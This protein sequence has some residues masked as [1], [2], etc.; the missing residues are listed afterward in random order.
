MVAI[1]SG[2]SLGLNLG[3]LATLGQQG[4][5]GQAAQGS[6]GER[7]YVDGTTGNLVLQREDDHLLA[8]G[9][10]S[11]A[12]RTYNSQGLFNDDNGDNWTSGFWVKPL[13]LAGTLN[14]AG[15][16]L[17]R[18]DS[19][20]SVATYAFS[21]GAYRST[22]G[23][24]AHDTITYVAADNQLEWREGS[25]GATQ[26]YE[27]G[28]NFRLLSAR[29][30]SGNALVY[31]YD[32]AGRVVS[33]ATAS[34]DVTFYDYRDGNLQQIRTVTAGSQG[35][36]DVRYA[37]DTDNRLVTVTVDLT[38]ADGSIA[39]GKAYTTTYGYEAGS[40]RIA[41][42][43]QSDGTSLSF[44]YTADGKVA[45][46]TNALGQATTFTY[47]VRSV[48]VRDAAN[49]AYTYNFDTSGRLAQVV[50]P[51]GTQYFTFGSNGD[52]L[53]QKDAEL[54]STT[55]QYDANGNQVL[56]CD[57]LG[58][59]I[60]R[61]FDARNQ[62][63]TETAYVV[64]DPDGA[65]VAT[66]QP[67]R[68]LTTRYVYD[69]AGRSLL[70]F[71]L[72]AEGRVTENRYDGFGQ[73]VAT[74]VYAGNTYPVGG[75]AAT[76][77]PPEA[78]LAAWAASQ[79]TGAVQRQDFSYDARGALVARTTFARVD[80]AGAGV[81]DGSESRETFAYDLNGRLLQSVSATG[82]STAFSY[83][84]LGRILGRT[85][86]LGQLTATQYLDLAA[87]DV[88]TLASGLAS[89][90]TY[91]AA[92]RLASLV[93]AAPD[94]TVLGVTHYFY[95]AGGRLVATQDPTG[96]CQWVLYDS[97]GRKA[98]D[99]DGN[100]SM[101]EYKYDRSDRLVGTI[102]YGNRVAAALLFDA[103]GAPATTLTLSVRPAASSADVKTWRTYDAA[104]RP[105][106]EAHTV[107]TANAVAVVETRYDGASR[108]MA[109]VQYA[110]TVSTPTASGASFVIALPAAS[111]SDRVTRYFYDGDGLRVGT[112]DAEGYLTARAYGAGGQLAE[113]LAYATATSTDPAQQ[114]GGDLAALRPAASAS[115]IRT[116]WL[117][118]GKGLVAGQVDGEGYLTETVR[119]AD[120]NAIRTVRYASRVTQTAIAS[121]TV[122]ALRPAGQAAD[123]V[124]RR[125]YDALGRL[126]QETNPEGTVTQYAYDVA[127]RLVATT[128][129]AGTAEARQQLERYDLQGRLTG[130]LGAEGAALL[131]PGQTQAEVD[132]IWAQYGSS[133]A[134]DAAG[135]R[136][137]T[138]DAA[139]NRTLFFYNEDGALTHT[140]N[141]LGEVRENLYDA[142]GRLAGTVAYA[143]RID[144]S[145]LQGGLVTAALTGAITSNTAL[146]SRTTISYTREDLVAATTDALGNVSSHAY[147]VFGDE[148]RLTQALGGAATLTTTYST[149]RRGLRTGSLAD[150][151][152][153][154]ASATIQYDAFGRAVRTIDA[155]GNVR[156][157]AYDRLGR[158]VALRDPLGGASTSSFD[159]FG[160]VLTQTD[161][162]GNSTT[163]AY[164][165][166]ARTMSVTTPEGFRTVT[167]YTRHG[168]VLS[169]T[170][171]KGQVTTYAYDREGRLLRTTTPLTVA[172]SSYDAAGRLLAS[173]DAAGNGVAYTYDAAN[174]L[175]ART[176]DPA[177]LA[178][179]TRYQYDAKGQQVAVTDADGVLTN[180]EYDRKGQVLKQTVDPAGLKLQTLYSYDAQGRVLSVTTP[181]GS[182]TQ[183][184][185]DALGRRTQERVDPNGLNL[186][187]Q[188][189]YDGNGN[190][191]TA[192]DATGNVT[193]YVYDAADRLQFTIDAAGGV[194]QDSYD[195]AGR[196]VRSASYATPINA[197]A[198]PAAPGAAQVQALLDAS[199]GQAQVENRVYD[200]D[201]RL[202]ATVDGTGAVLRYT[203]DA[204]GN[205]VSRTAYATA[206]D[207][208]NWLPG[209]LPAP[210][211]DAAR[212]LQLRTVYDALNRAVY[213]IDAL[214]G[215]VFQAYD[216]NGRV[217]QRIAYATPVKAGTALTQ[218]ALAAATRSIASAA[219]DASTRNVYDAAGRL[220]WSADGLG[221][222]TQSVYD[223]N[224]NLL[225]LVEYATPVAAGAAP[226]SVAAADG[227]RTTVMAYDAANR[228]V[229]TIDA[230]GA[231]TEQ[232]Y[233]GNGQ[234][235][236]RTAYATPLS[237]IPAPGATLLA[238]GALL[239]AAP[240]A[241]R[242]TSF[243]Y[244]AAGRQTLAI[245]AEGG[246]VETVWDAAGRAMRVTQYATAVS[247]GLL[248]LPKAAAGD[249]VTRNTYDAA[250]RL[251][252]SVDALGVVSTNTYD[253]LGRLRSVL[254]DGL[255]EQFAYD[256]AG[257]VVQHTDALGAVESFR[258]NALGN[259]EGFTD[260]NGAYWQYGYDA[261]GRLASE[262]SPVAQ[263]RNVA[264]DDAGVLVDNGV[265]SAS[266][267]TRYAYDALGRLVSRTEAAG[268]PQEER[269]TRYDYDPLGHQVKVTQPGFQMY[270]T[271]ED[272]IA[273][274][275]TGSAVR[276]EKAVTPQTIT[277]YD[278]LG[279][280]V[281]NRELAT[282]QL[283]QKVYDRLGR[284]AYDID[285]L[286]YVTAY[287]RNAFGEV[288]QLVRYE[289][290]TT[291]ANRSVTQAAQAAT[292][293]ETLA[294]LNALPSHDLDRTLLA[295]YDR[296]G[297]S[298]EVGQP[299]VYVS[300]LDASA[301][302]VSGSVPLATRK[303]YDAFG[304]VIAEQSLR[305]AA[306]AWSTTRH[307]YDQLGREVATIDPLG[308][309]T[310]RSF[311]SRGNL[312]S[313]REYTTVVASW[314]PTGPKPAAGADDRITEYTYD[315]L[316]RKLTETR[317]GIEY[318][319]APD[320]SSTRGAA[321]TRYAYDAVGNQVRVT[322]ALGG[323][324]STWYDALGRV[325]AVAAPARAVDDGS[326]AATSRTPLT[327][328]ARDARGNAVVT[329]EYALGAV[330]G[331]P[332]PLA[333]SG[334]DRNSFS[335]FDA[336][337][338]L[339]QTVDAVGAVISFS[340]D[341]AG[342]VAKR[343]QDVTDVD[344][345]MRTRFEVSVYDKLGRLLE[346]RTPASTAVMQGS[347][348]ADVSQAQA[349]LVR[350]QMQYNGF[351][352]LVRRGVNGSG[353]EF[354]EYDKAGRL[355]RTNSGDG[356]ARILLYD[357][358]G[359]VT[360]E[361]RSAGAGLGNIDITQLPNA[362]TADANPMTRRTDTR[363]DAAGHVVETWQAA[364]EEK[365]VGVVGVQKQFITATI[366]GS[367]Q[368]TVVDWPDNVANHVVLGWNS[369]S[370]LGSGD[371]KVHVEYRTP[372]HLEG[373]G[374]DPDG[375][376]IPLTIVGGTRRSYDSGI[377]TAEEGA[378]RADLAW[379]EPAGNDTGVG[380]IDRIV[381]YKKDVDG[382]WQAV[383]DEAPG[384]GSDQLDFAVPVESDGAV[385]L[386]MRP[387]GSSGDSG[388]WTARIVNF[389]DR[390]FY[391]TS[392]LG[393]GNYEYRVRVTPT[394]Q[395]SR[396]SASGTVQLTRPL[397]NAITTPIKFP[398]PASSLLAWQDPAASGT[399]VP[400]AFRYRQAGST[401]D[402]S[403][404][405]ISTQGT[406]DMVDTARLAPGT[407]QFELLWM[408]L[409]KT[410]QHATGTFTITP[411]QAGYT[412]PQVNLR[413]ITN[414]QV[415]W[416]GSANYSDPILTWRAA[417]ATR[418]EYQRA[419]GTW[420]ALA[421]D[422]S[423]QDT[424]IGIPLGYQ[425]ASLAGIPAGSYAYRIYAGSPPTQQA[426]GVLT[427]NATAAG[428]YETQYVSV[429]VYTPRV[430]FYL[431][432]TQ[433]VQVTGPVTRRVWVVDFV[434]PFASQETDVPAFQIGHYEDR[435]TVETYTVDKVVGQQ[436]FYAYDNDGSLIYDL[437][438]TTQAQQVW[439]G[440]PMPT[441][442]LQDTTP[443]W[444]PA[445]VVP[446][447]PA[448][449]SL[450]Q[451]L[452]A[453][454]AAISTS[455][456]DKL[457][458][459]A[460][461]SQNTDDRWLRPDVQ[462]KTDRWGNVV[463]TTDPRSASWK[464]SYRYNASNQLVQQVQPDD[465]GAIS[466][467]SP[468]TSIFYDKLGR[469]VAVRDANGHVS[470]Q[471]FDAAGNLVL[472]RHADAYAATYGYSIFGDKVRSTSAEGRT[473][474]FTYDKLGRQ[475][476]A[477]KGVADVFHLDDR[478]AV[479]VAVRNLTEQWS[480]DQLGRKLTAINANGEQTQYVYDLQGNVLQTRLPGGRVTRGAYDAWGNKIADQGADGVAAATWT[481]KAFGQLVAHKDLGGTRY[482]YTY[483][484]AR[485][486]LKQTN[487]DGQS[488][489]MVYDAAGQL[490]S[491]TDAATKKVTTYAYDL[492]GRHLRERTVQAGLTY[493]DNHLAYDARGNL[494][495]VADGR[496]HMVLQYD[497][498]GNRTHVWTHVDYRMPD[499][500]EG[501]NISDRYFQYDALNRQTVVDA[502]DA[503]G[504]LGTQGH[505]LTYDRDGNRLTDTFAD[506]DRIVEASGRTVIVG[507]DALSGTAAYDQA[508]HTF[509][510][511]AGLSTEQY[512]YDALSRL[513][514]VV[515]DGVQTDV[516]LYDGAD[517]VVQSG[518][519]AGLP[520]GNYGDLVAQSGG[521]EVRQYLY[522]QAGR[523]L[524]EAVLTPGRTVKADIRWDPTFSTTS[525]GVTY[526][527][528][529][530]D[531]LG[532]V[533]GYVVQDYQAGIVN[534]FV[535]IHS[536]Y[537]GI[538]LVSTEGT[539]T[540]LTPATTTQDYDVN[541]FL[542][543]IHDG[544]QAGATADRSIVN[545][546]SGRVLYVKQGTTVQRQLI[547]NGEVLG[548][549]GG[550]AAPAFDFSYAPVSAS[551]PSPSPGAYTVRPG[552]T[553]QS[554]ALGAYGD[555][556][557]WYRIAEANGLASN[558]DLKAGATLNIP[559]RISSIH[560]N[561]G[562]FT[563]YDP[564]QIEGDKTPT[565]AMPQSGHGHGCGG[566]GTL[567]MVVVAVAATVF[568]AGLLAPAADGAVF[569]IGGTFAAGMGAL[570]TAGLGM[571]GG[572]LAAA[573]GSVASQAVGMAVGAQ[574][575]FNW[576]SVALSAGAGAFTAGLTSAANSPGGA[577][578]GTIFSGQGTGALMARAA[579]SNLAT[580]GFG[581][582]TGLQDHF[583]WRGVAAAAVGSGVGNAVSSA[584]P[585][586]LS[587][588]ANRAI[589]GL[590]AGTAA[591]FMHGGRVVVQ[592]VV[593]DAFGN[594]IGG[595]LAAQ[596]TS[597][598]SAAVA[599][600]PFPDADGTLYGA[601]VQLPSLNSVAVW[602][603]IPYS[604]TPSDTS[605]DVLIAAGADYTGRVP[606]G[607][608]HLTLGNPQGDAKLDG[609]ARNAQTRDR[610]AQ[611]QSNI[612]Q[613]KSLMNNASA[614]SSGASAAWA[615]AQN[616]AT[617][618]LYASGAGDVREYA[619]TVAPAPVSPDMPT[620]LAPTTP[621]VP[622]VDL[623][624]P[625][626]PTAVASPE[627]GSPNLGS[628]FFNPGWGAGVYSG[629]LS[630]T[631]A[632]YTRAPASGP[633]GRIGGTVNGYQAHHLNQDAVYRASI[634]YRSGQSILLPG[635]ALRDVG[636]AHYQAHA[637]LENW[638]E[639]YRTGESLGSVPTNAQYGRALRQS[640]IDGGMSPA[641]ATQYADVARQQ[642]LASSQA[643]DA[644]VPRIPRRMSQP[645]GNVVDAD[646][647]A[648]RGLSKN[649]VLVGRG[650]TVVGATVDG[651]SL[652]SQYEKGVQTG[653]YS[654]LHREGV[655][656]AGGWAGVYAV[657]TAGAEFGAGFG[658]AFSPVGAVIGGFVGGVI[659]G[660]IGYVGGSYAS[661]GIANDVGLLPP[662]TPK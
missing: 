28:G 547:V 40:K 562:T 329:T 67:A 653:D 413:P 279:N 198:L 186:R 355:W 597:G 619:E 280:A 96:V 634:S 385:A 277:C 296:D 639:S 229:L 434:Y 153:I 312:T 85:D 444:T 643:D 411:P 349:G 453:A 520:A 559:N 190:V 42:V 514:S 543:G 441:P 276:A 631:A 182:L 47:G 649:L 386:E 492:S 113:E 320:G 183:Y 507:Y 308:Y 187:R 4:V 630:A 125:S 147:D 471:G 11:V 650:A 144:V 37:Y 161:A 572:A 302:S 175:L 157:Q 557:L 425:S 221:A 486:L 566:L 406:L 403:E 654:D 474:T 162:L 102:R 151:A 538:V 516:R 438:Y 371:V 270:N 237:A 243:A 571:E 430:A 86:A 616:Q 522:D 394:G 622:P 231:V 473:V 414:L 156:E 495:D 206:I 1:V 498:V 613:L 647:W 321:I 87:S 7:V 13:A 64:P 347:Y 580:Q 422:N 497:L 565:L 303:S 106:R 348:V 283:T 251:A 287:T 623:Q 34:G 575:G 61:T 166:T 266:V 541:G 376:T 512:R 330:A 89:T 136:I 645:G 99:I 14:A 590:A 659:G 181:G 93:D 173:M 227:D 656:V 482:A 128:V 223:G 509:A 582:A 63:L 552:D 30:A 291:L 275:A 80:A 589:S 615:A 316:G 342:R 624:V 361:I 5:F 641:D 306:Y 260:K 195:A 602:A 530:Y 480:Y 506:D 194:T 377:F 635:D 23:S 199:P 215:V 15:S 145:G 53:L 636:S 232:A 111:A 19:D 415:L 479:L 660:A 245:D 305:N 505:R 6:S 197:N 200:R 115:D 445:R 449:Y 568:T 435:T 249:R 364:R 2:N 468:V 560:N 60:S 204:N 285:A 553:L 440:G 532:N 55:Y 32:A 576:K 392:E 463:E 88:L 513:V 121:S 398:T 487:S 525:G 657:G 311:D 338:H 503:A 112:L 640:L 203:Y 239:V 475:L 515:K 442:V 581:V 289:K 556:S 609:V 352:E 74:L 620:P 130:E 569:S 351:G 184:I 357:A 56:Q 536:A 599:K 22:E 389:G 555:S 461:T 328:F 651:Y 542:T 416:T 494:R 213:T 267:L 527:P 336:A 345:F 417:N 75:L 216:G 578:Y 360:A 65:S 381:V 177:G 591:Q 459:A 70:R 26:R 208:A 545:D 225:R 103:T 246:A 365:Q 146:D 499:G 94:G 100:G 193:R 150:G 483:D 257:R 533:M 76:A 504:N 595:S 25:T 207:V 397:L 421:I 82:A 606:S 409:R 163:Y 383:I 104:G 286:G 420:V 31:G 344:G 46:V 607:Q 493:Q 297:R 18:T 3:S 358:Q 476:S 457:Q 574:K 142:Q 382:V 222:V 179:T 484:K 170:D 412:V 159:A 605:D 91:D 528:N 561:A 126:Q 472:E 236:R 387:A 612:V 66:G 132:A 293:A 180:I 54:R 477:A 238:L 230:V 263:L 439:V 188:W 638:W 618:D 598:G 429:P 48:L 154:A 241:D 466:A 12:L 405:A 224:G 519:A 404:L 202:A 262:T 185:Y 124:T 284:L 123:R 335:V 432:I 165:A 118:D 354:F 116:V 614:S 601:P 174:R 554:I 596:S 176:L 167:A 38:P 258:Y 217:L 549:Y 407:Y 341:A 313:V 101:T 339:L 362:Q 160:R 426:T 294:A 627:P 35:S 366:V 140:V 458:Q 310:E 20:G 523:A 508:A 368:L 600:T 625:A 592:Q 322:D 551:N 369:L 395:P 467:S 83:D 152:G 211:A 446:A 529:G 252:G 496:V 9:P 98:A 469:Q 288:T 261:A 117:Y 171:G 220:A 109:V 134:Y 353:E 372:S 478:Q 460:T 24:G 388:W 110:G 511:S 234:V 419:D 319:D 587:N 628:S 608:D 610:I 632:L 464:T 454:S 300:E 517:R 149:D 36:I 563:P 510:R 490:T 271:A 540:R 531:A 95:D 273:N 68:P 436:P 491:I 379:T 410:G 558:A 548:L 637:S 268:R 278:A 119:D 189:A 196:L 298:V 400:Q 526:S 41:S 359:H 304:D 655:R 69:A 447:M 564:S 428:H 481:Y 470:G 299:D 59:T 452:A 292:R 318:S 52:L 148:I 92:G 240:A 155:N 139:G 343:W 443:P 205:V 27:A 485:Q 248:A 107:G 662:G 233:D 350:Q 408:P 43:V 331:T 84:G 81:R 50:S 242:V 437:G 502:V 378:S 133:H 58:N 393:V 550:D 137:A 535:N 169:I 427:I 539:S 264:L 114:G 250:G 584:L 326:G 544:G 658:M 661:V 586:A 456:G 90:K 73:R 337:G 323:V 255:A 10:D 384:Y 488:L 253:A 256:A 127:G 212:D 391:D 423:G 524:R 334:D 138:T 324:T 219:K 228:L 209:T 333:P 450:V 396:I 424:S 214:N 448:Q 373:G 135:R 644:P 593:V 17:Q 633:Y 191:C 418:A 210:V 29:D 164:D 71:T 317:Q 192:T 301:K 399:Q 380:C 218:A 201:G 105:V 433:K 281:A 315:A 546:A 346:V 451:G 611:L 172:S 375:A 402:W 97:A 129:A 621:Y 401:G 626:S 62:L 489:A 374:Q 617:S 567:L 131:A 79:P 588:F 500:G 465:A 141:A 8:V 39:D 33:A 120:G 122:A 16:Q 307:Y 235:V 521:L 274:G 534:E 44:T 332:N 594:A 585:A 49:V 21:A 518:P 573:A 309:L 629:A 178:L 646:L 367:A 108:V 642:R 431:P 462:Q 265:E 363:Y 254:R 356:V 168:Q 77:V 648:A 269:T 259:K 327:V 45:S 537:D 158:I 325:I 282:G 78:D 455:D 603:N 577:L 652:Y 579:L 72:S 340:Y 143:M 583:D 295:S 501:E 226:D 390:Y 370:A 604:S 290:A 272:V 244:D 314:S 247:P 570:T 57:A 51:V